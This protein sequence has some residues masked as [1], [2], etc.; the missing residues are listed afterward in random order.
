MYVGFELPLASARGKINKLR[1]RNEDS[2][3]KV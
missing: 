2:G 1:I 3:I